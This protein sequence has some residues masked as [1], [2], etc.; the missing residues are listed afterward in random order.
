LGAVLARCLVERPAGIDDLL[1][2]MLAPDP[3]RRPDA[4]AVLAALSPRVRATAL[5]AT[6]P[7]AVP[8]APTEP[9]D[10]TGRTLGDFVVREPIGEGGFGAV[11][12]AEQPVLGREAVIKVLHGKL[13]TREHYAHRFLREAR[14]ASKLDHPYAA[15]VYA[16]GV[17]PDGQMWIAMELVRGT[18]LDQ[19]LVAQGPIPLERFVPLLDRIC[20]VVHTAHEAGIVHRDLKPANVMVIARAGRLLP[21]LL[22]FGIAK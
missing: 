2:R 4:A 13:R 6:L 19:L 1:A 5:A 20:E 22:D 7:V 8:T 10:L 14:L 17:E 11:Y 9:A 16:F 12:R 18:P 3:E 15:H 21:K